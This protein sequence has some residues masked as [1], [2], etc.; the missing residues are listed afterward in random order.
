MKKGLKLRD[1]LYIGMFVLLAGLLAGFAI[2]QVT[3][4]S[5]NTA[6]GY[7]PLQQI[8]KTSSNMASV[9]GNNNGIIDQSDDAGSLNGNS[10][11]T[12]IN[13]AASTVEQREKCAKYFDSSTAATIGSGFSLAAKM[14]IPSE[15]I[16]N[17]CTV[18]VYDKSTNLLS[19][20]FQYTQINKQVS[21]TTRGYWTAFDGASATRGVNGMYRY[22]VNGV[23]DVTDTILNAGSGWFTQNVIYDDSALTGGEITTSQW[24]V[25]MQG[26]SSKPFEIWI[27]G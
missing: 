6:Q 8:A 22:G 23:H 15:C 3:G 10:Y 26:A 21:G 27:C 13:N 7:H 1:N 9:D 19:Y 4:P 16:D 24:I 5:V 14:S 25:S 11:T 17:T 20:S 18:A 2:G 12:V